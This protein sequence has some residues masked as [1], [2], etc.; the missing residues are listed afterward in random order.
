MTAART[1]E[2]LPWLAAALG[3]I[4]LGAAIATNL[5][6]AFL[7]VVVLF[8]VATLAAPA[9]AWVLCALV[10]ALAFRGLVQL[11]ALPS[12]AT[13]I[14]LPLAWGALAVGLLKRRGGSPLLTTILRGLAALALA[15]LLAWAFHPSE[16]LRPV[17]YLALLG[18]P[19]AII[20]A[21]LADPPSPRMRQALERTLLVLLIVQLPI[22]A[23]QLVALGPADHVQGTLYGAGAGAHVISGVIAVGAIWILARGAGAGRFGAF[24][25]P[26]VLLLLIVPFVADA[27]Q[28]ILALPAALLA[29]SPGAGRGMAIART[30]I[31]V[32]AVVA[33][34]AFF[35][36]GGA[37]EL[38]IKNAE[39]GQGGKQ[40]TARFVWDHARGDAASIA[41]G[42]GPAETVSRAAF[43]TTDLFQRGGSPIAVVGLAPA[44][45]A[46]EAQSTA[47]Q[48]SG[49]GTSFNSGTSSALGVLGDIG[50]VG[51][52]AYAGL[53]LAMFLRL[54]R[55]R[56]AE[57][58]A[59]AAGFAMFLVLGLFFDWWE[60]PPFGVFIG[61]LAG[62]ALSRGAR[63]DDGRGQPDASAGGLVALV[64]PNPLA[65]VTDSRR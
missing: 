65:A 48:A 33:L 10:A 36:A 61:V 32:A 17:L 34:F 14:D 64:P 39:H 13:F 2:A 21:L 54:R 60:Q 31:V 53:L 29:W 9:G 50:I 51:L 40:A 8:G 43:M 24:R 7:L 46:V 55:D 62:L 3:S 11:N 26:L 15:I 59:S 23:V 41:F 44:E 19:F 20:A 1:R 30:G 5:Q 25:L 18:E 56:S 42:Q 38:F 4:A 27:K 16:V 45:L 22:A 58:V 6:V 52:A 37:T 57:G 12:V 49:G 63:R 47:L 28:V 35:P